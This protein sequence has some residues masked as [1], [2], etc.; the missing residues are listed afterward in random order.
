MRI[1][2][3]TAA[4]ILP[5]FFFL[6]IGGTIING[7]WRTES[8]KIPAVYREGDLK[9]EYDPGDIRGSYT[10]GDLEKAFK[11]PVE[12]LARA[13]G[14]SEEENP[15]SLQIKIFEARYGVIDGHE[16][17]TD[18]MRL[19]I[20]LYLDRPYV[21]E[22]DTAIP[23]PAYSILKKEG[24]SSSEAL[25]VHVDRIVS[26]EEAADH[27]E[28]TEVSHEETVLTEIKGKTTFADLLDRGLSKEQIEDA[29]SLPMGARADSVRD[30]CVA[31]GI[32]FSGV[33]AKLQEMLDALDL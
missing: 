25:A 6:G 2:A 16:V 32:E 1:R 3:N 27:S 31:Q 26:L 24:A 4:L 22:E 9:G 17:G 12:T 19:F 28:G 18:S 13:Y 30:Y 23:H 29:L 15:S 20:A 33:K 7:Y 8:S 10:L 14:L 11:V 5:L 21:P